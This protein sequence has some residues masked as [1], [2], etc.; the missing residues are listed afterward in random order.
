LHLIKSVCAF[1]VALVVCY[2]QR[3][4]KHLRFAVDPTAH[5][6]RGQRRMACRQ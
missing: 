6:G 2:G 4:W 1:H 3:G 5:S